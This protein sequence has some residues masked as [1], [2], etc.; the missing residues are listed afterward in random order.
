MATSSEQNFSFTS[1]H[2]VILIEQ[3][4]KCE[5]VDEHVERQGHHHGPLPFFGPVFKQEY[6][7]FV[8]SYQYGDSDF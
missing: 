5:K 8:L 1:L 7:W 3:S 6:Q 2:E 4:V